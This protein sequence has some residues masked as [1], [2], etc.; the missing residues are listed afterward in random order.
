MPESKPRKKKTATTTRPAP[1]ALAA[2]ATTG[3]LGFDFRGHRFVIDV[4]TADFGRAM[5]AMKVAARGTDITAALDKMLDSLEAALGKEQ[6]QTLYEVAPDMFSSEATQ[7]DFWE[8]FARLTV[9][10]DLGEPLAS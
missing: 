5:F 3:Q 6:V 10:T 8:Q 7:R 2:E 9:G 1:N 4:N